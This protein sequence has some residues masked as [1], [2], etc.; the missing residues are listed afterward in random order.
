VDLEQI[1]QQILTVRHDLSREDILKKIYEKKRSTEDYFIDEVAARLVASELGVELPNT[2]DPLRPEI[3][4]KDLV[5]GL[6]DVTIIGRVIDVYPVQTFSRSDLTEGKVA[7]LLLVGKTGTI[8]VVLW[9]EQV[10]P[11][12]AEKIQQGQIIRVSHGYVREGL[13]GKPELHVGRR[14]E[15]KISPPEQE[16]ELPPTATKL[17]KV[18]ALKPNMIDVNVLARVCKVGA[19]RQFRRSNGQTGQVASIHLLD[20]TGPIQLSLWNENAEAAENLKTGDTVLLEHAYT[21][22]RFDRTELNL[23]T[24]GSLTINPPLP[25]AENLPPA[26]WENP[27]SQR[28]KI[29]DIKNP[30]EPFTV[31]AVVDSQPETKEITTRKN[32]KV[33]LTSFDI[34]DETGKIRVNLWREQAE[35]ASNLTVGTKLRL[36]NIYAKR[37]FSNMLELVSRRIT[38]VEMLSSVEATAQNKLE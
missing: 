32:E 28:R 37:G 5:T 16:S 36:T 26:R 6:N 21:R 20:E 22:Q 27:P 18:V 14:G 35:A 23:G 34:A 9:D 1:V 33:L 29:S 11:V 10:Q 15:L 7:R 13:D 8:K 25:E 3:A 38:T 12:E 31:E 24:R 19:I 2:E 17:T 30:D 4:I